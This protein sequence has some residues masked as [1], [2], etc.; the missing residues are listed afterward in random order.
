MEIGKDYIG[1]TTPFYCHDGKG[2]FLFGK[3]GIACRDEREHWDPGSGKLEFGLTIKENVLKKIQEEYG[4][5]GMIQ[6]QLPAHYKI[7]AIGWFRLDALPQPIHEGFFYT[8]NVYK[9]YFKKY[10]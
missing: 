2:N 5:G 7:D 10:L 8:F 9:N 3:R 4:C 6:E 1:V